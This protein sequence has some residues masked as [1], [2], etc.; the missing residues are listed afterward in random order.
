MLMLSV[1]SLHSANN[2]TSLAQRSDHLQTLLPPPNS[3]VALL[4][5]IIQLLCPVHLLQQLALHLVF[6]VPGIKVSNYDSFANGAK[7]KKELTAQAST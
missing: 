5:Q 1:R 4:E 3:I 6:R 2:L 7:R